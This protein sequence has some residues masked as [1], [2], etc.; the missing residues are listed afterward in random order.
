[1]F[2]L[3]FA[4]NK[5]FHLRFIATLLLGTLTITSTGCKS[6][7]YDLINDE[8]ELV[9]VYSKIINARDSS[10][11]DSLELYSIKFE[12]ALIATLTKNTETLN[13]SFK[14]LKYN[15]YCNINTSKDGNFRI[16][17]WD[18]WTGGSM[19]FFKSIYQWKNGSKVYLKSQNLEENDAGSY[20]SNI[21]TTNFDSKKVYLVISNSIYSNKECSQSISSFQIQNNLLIDSLKIFK[22]EN[23]ISNRIDINYDFLSVVNRPERPVELIKF[24]EKMNTVLVN[25]LND[26]GEVLD[27]IRIYRLEEVK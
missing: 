17:S 12:K 8:N 11:F 21:F 18:T 2:K 23:E 15:K 4:V 6:K 10:K 7:S 19:H 3:E 14:S 5:N 24:D 22:S 1:M 20:C 9:S 26:I 16:Y 13:Y 25:E 27:K